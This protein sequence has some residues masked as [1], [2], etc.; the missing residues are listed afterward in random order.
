MWKPMFVG[1]RNDEPEETPPKYFIENKIKFRLTVIAVAVTYTI[2][3]Y[4]VQKW[5]SQNHKPNR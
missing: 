4:K 1:S 5:N 3:S 2:F